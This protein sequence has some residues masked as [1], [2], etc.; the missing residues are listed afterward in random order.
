MDLAGV[1]LRL[2]A[3][4]AERGGGV[5]R[6]I[7][8]TNSGADPQGAGDRNRTGTRAATSNCA[9]SAGNNPVY[10][11]EH[12]GGPRPLGPGSAR[13]ADS[14][15]AECSGLHGPATRAGLS[16]HF[17]PQTLRISR[18]STLGNPLASP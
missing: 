18:L 13:S 10:D 17:L 1:R 5:R 9:A 4:A 7:A 16:A 8:A 6:Q 2:F 14:R 12:I 11:A 3:C 15:R